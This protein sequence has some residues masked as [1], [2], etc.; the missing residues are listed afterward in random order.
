MPNDDLTHEHSTPVDADH[1]GYE[2]TDVNVSGI[3]VFL[4]GLFGTVLIFFVVCFMLGKVINNGIQASYAS[5]YGEPNKWHGGPA[6]KTKLQNLESNA[7]MEQTE[8]GKMAAAFPNPRLDID[9]GNQATAELHERED[10]LLD[11]YSSIPGD[12]STIRIPISR[13]MEL[14]AQR[15]LPVNAAA[16]ATSP[17]LAGDVKPEVQAPL[18]TGFARTGYEIDVMETRAQRLSSEKASA[19]AEHASAK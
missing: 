18:T 17:Q 13:A 10:L 4:A 16:A 12:S 5:D 14:I 11:H 3:A 15:G 6:A 1:P 7:A 8:F 19:E 9:D 2:T